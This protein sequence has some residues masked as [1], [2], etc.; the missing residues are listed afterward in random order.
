MGTALTTPT[1]WLLR[2]KLTE[3]GSL[4]GNHGEQSKIPSETTEWP[5]DGTPQMYPAGRENG[6][7]GQAGWT[8]SSKTVQNLS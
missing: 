1:G 2:D 5:L 4:T 8:K 6:R 7:A 3:Q